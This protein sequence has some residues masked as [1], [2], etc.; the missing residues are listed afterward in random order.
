MHASHKTGFHCKPKAPIQ[1]VVGGGKKTGQRVLKKKPKPVKGKNL[2]GLGWAYARKDGASPL[3]HMTRGEA[4][5]VLWKT[6]NPK[7]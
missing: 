4:A 2:G 6:L 1:K 5:V 3:R 7:P